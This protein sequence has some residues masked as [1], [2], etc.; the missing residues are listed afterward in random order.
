V[1]LAGYIAV[2]REGHREPRHQWRAAGTGRGLT[3]AE[4]RGLASSLQNISLQLPRAIGPAVGG[5]LFHAGY[6]TLPFLIG[7]T[8]QLVYLILYVRF[9]G[10]HPA[11]R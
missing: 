4:R 5:V 3:R 10:S 2:Y 9:F 1:V 7:A 6:L 8:L 11:A